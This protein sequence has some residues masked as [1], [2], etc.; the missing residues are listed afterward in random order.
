MLG[1]GGA[2]KSDEFSDKFQRAG[3]GGAVIFNP[4]FI[5]QFLDLYKSFFQM[6]SEKKL[7]FNFKKVR[8]GS[9]AVWI[10]PTIHPIW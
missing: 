7:Q 1:K 4:K 10:F 2:T 8:G 9:K 5:L 3:G 6:F